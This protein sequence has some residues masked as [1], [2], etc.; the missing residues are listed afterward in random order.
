LITQQPSNLSPGE[1][2]HRQYWAKVNWDL[3]FGQLMYLPSYRTWNSTYVS[4]FRGT[5]GIDTDSVTDKDTFWTH[6]LHLASKPDSKLAWQVGAFYYDNALHNNNVVH[7]FPSGAF[8]R[9]QDISRDTTA[10]SGFGEATYPFTDITRVTAG[11]RYDSTQVQVNEIFT[12]NANCITTIPGGVDSVNYCK[13]ENLVKGTL[14]GDAGKRTFNKMTY[15]LRLDHDLTTEN[16][17]YAMVSTGVSPGDVLLTVDLKGTAA[18]NPTYGVPIPKDIHSETLTSYEIGSKNR[19]LD[20]RL[21][22]NGGLFYYDY[23]AYQER[24]STSTARS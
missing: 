5:G 3:G 20:S 21:Q 1:N 2:E 12:N 22:I 14:S 15:K 8:Y 16:M 24:M 17:V 9:G 13:P 4:R 6:E 10:W 11:L 19:F 7:R 18:T 23:G